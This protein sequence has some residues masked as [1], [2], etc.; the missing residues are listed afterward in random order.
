M[1]QYERSKKEIRKIMKSIAGKYR[2]YQVFRDFIVLSACTISNRVDKSQ[3]ESREKMYMDTIAKY[4]KEEADKFAEMLALTVL[5]YESKMGDFIGELYME[6]EFGNEDTGQFFTPYHVS[7]L[8]AGLVDVRPDKKGII[9]LNEPA[10]GS[11]GMIV[12]YAERLMLEG[13]NYQ[14][15]L[16]VVCNDI[17]YD[18]VKMC[19]IQLSLLG[20]DAVVMQGDTITLKMNEIWYTPMHILNKVREQRENR[21][22]QMIDAMN[23]LMQLEQEPKKESA[24]VVPEGQMTIFDYLEGFDG[25]E[26]Q[27]KTS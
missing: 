22:K 24:L 2:L 21:T 18:V 9:T 11:G 10:S 15:Q 26:K 14:K 27:K 1:T 13:I 7:K 19:Y 25:E 23:K 17:D 8:M 6:M 12:A 16:R 4:D 20:I 5:A 3:F